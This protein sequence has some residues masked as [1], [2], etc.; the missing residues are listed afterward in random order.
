ML[1]SK[2]ILTYFS[3]V[4]KG[5]WQ[6]TL[7]AIKKKEMVEEDQVIEALNDVSTETLAILDK[8]Y[9]EYWKVSLAQPPLVLFYKG[10]ISLLNDANYRRVSVVGSRR[11][12]SYGVNTVTKLI[13]GLPKNTIIVSG[14]ACGIDA[15]AHRAAL[16]NGLKTIA[17]LGS[18]ID[19][20]YPKV[21]ENLYKE[22]LATG[23]LILSEYPNA[24]EPQKENFVFRNRLVAS[25]GEFL[26]VGES[27]ER[28]GTST[29]INYAL[30]IGNNVG[31]IPYEVGKGSSCNAYIK[32][33]AILVDSPEDIITNL[34]RR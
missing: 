23:G 9:P 4:N 33:G 25:I 20:V 15:A 27:Y 28:S 8:D 17:I 7:D 24:T 34:R 5:D 21:N 22:I 26:L 32:E 30:H 10:D 19:F 14:L 13:S 12:T 2:Q 6:L 31:C 18:G 11:C 3:F 16:D 29:T 1:S